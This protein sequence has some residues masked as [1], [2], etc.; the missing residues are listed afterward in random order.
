M[1][2][3]FAIGGKFATVLNPRVVKELEDLDPPWGPCGYG[4]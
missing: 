2:T 4:D 3:A 1:S